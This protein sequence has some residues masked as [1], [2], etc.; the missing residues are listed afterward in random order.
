MNKEKQISDLKQLI[1]DTKK[2]RDSAESS[3]AKLQYD[4]F[5][6]NLSCE[7]FELETGFTSLTRKMV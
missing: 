6:Y 3:S 1:R 7:I 4:K 5:L 2:N